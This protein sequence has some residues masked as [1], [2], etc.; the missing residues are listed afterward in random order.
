M[1][2]QL[3]IILGIRERTYAPVITKGAGTYTAT[4]PHG[5]EEIYFRLWSGGGKGAG[6]TTS[7]STHYHGGGGSGCSWQGAIRVQKGDVVTLT[8]GGGSGY[9]R[10]MV[11]SDTLVTCGAGGGGGTVGGG[12][13]PGGAGGVVTVAS[14]DRVATDTLI[15]GNRGG[16]SS[17]TRGGHGV[18]FTSIKKGAADIFNS[19]IGHSSGGGSGASTV[20]GGASGGGGGGGGYY[21]G[22]SGSGAPAHHHGGFGGGGGAGYAVIQYKKSPASPVL[23]FA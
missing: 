19:H 11:G 3:N 13:G 22:G 5:V 23:N 6:Y 7:G 21:N 10:V 9:S 2:G 17:G 12:S 16:G 8:V 4:I 18:G 20:W 15:N 1:S 14:D